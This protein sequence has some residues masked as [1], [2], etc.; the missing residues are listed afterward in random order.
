MI[1]SVHRLTED[2]DYCAVEGCYATRYSPARWAASP[3]PLPV[4]RAH[5]IES[6]DAINARR[7][8]RRRTGPSRHQLEQA[9]AD[10][11]AALDEHDSRTGDGDR[12]ANTIRGLFAR[13]YREAL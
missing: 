6:P 3:C 11:R 9:L 12:L 13:L 1:A 2:D 7:H 4:D 8:A 10:I 5:E